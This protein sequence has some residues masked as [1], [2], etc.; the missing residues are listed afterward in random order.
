MATSG[1][2]GKV[3]TICGE[4]CSTKPRTKDGNGRYYCKPCYEQANAQRKARA[5]SARPAAADVLDL[6]SEP[7]SM[8]MLDR[9]IASAPPVAVT[10]HCSQCGF[11]LPPGGIICTHCGF[12]EQTKSVVRKTKVKQAPRGPTGGVIWPPLVGIL[13]MII[14]ACGLLF[15]GGV[16]VLFFIGSSNAPFS[17]RLAPLAALS[18][19]TWLGVWVLRDGWRIVRRDSDGITWMRYWAMAKLL[20]FGT[21]LAGFMS[22]PVRALDEALTR[23]QHGETHLTASDIKARILLIMLWFMLWPIFVM[24]F[25]FLPRIQTDVEQWD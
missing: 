19:L 16:L 24:V 11:V 13:S 12:N 7:A 9:L 15:Y 22:I 21:C 20:I 6:E 1:G 4:D 10:A 17:A 23:A 8:N 2:S 14:G 25:F 5:V 18:L 3:C